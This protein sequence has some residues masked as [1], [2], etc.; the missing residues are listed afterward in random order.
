MMF[1]SKGRTADAR[2]SFE[3]ALRHNPKHEPAR[4]ALAELAPKGVSK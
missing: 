4:E 1:A 3:A 2:A